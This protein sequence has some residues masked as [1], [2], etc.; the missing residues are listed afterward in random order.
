MEQLT[1]HHLPTEVFEA[2]ERESE[3][4]RKPLKNTVVDLLRQ[5]LRLKPAHSKKNGL[6]RLAGTGP[7]RSIGASKLPSPSPRRSTRSCGVEPLLPRY[8]RVQQFQE[9]RPPGRGYP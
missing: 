3:R 6:A 7:R 1:I 9:R 8:V 2:L 5:A 4:L